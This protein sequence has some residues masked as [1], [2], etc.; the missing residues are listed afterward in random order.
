MDAIRYLNR[1]LDPA[2]SLAEILFGLIMALTCTLGASLLAAI[3]RE[4][5]RTTLLAALGCNIAWGII[6]AALYVMGKAFVRSRNRSL[7]R[8]IRSA[9]DD[10]AALAV[11]REALEPTV[12]SHGRH[13]DC[14]WLYRSLHGIV[15]NAV[16]VAMLFVVGFY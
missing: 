8:A 1:F 15:A 12:G 3:D 14:E 10:A 13:E 4:I 7:M 6:D 5:L 2:E 9:P 16:Q 11:V